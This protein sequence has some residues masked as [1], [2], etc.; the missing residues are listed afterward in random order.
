M[1][2]IDT[3]EGYARGRESSGKPF[4]ITPHATDELPRYARAISFA[5]AGSITVVDI[6][7]E[8]VTIPSGS[9]APGAM[10]PMEIK[11]VR[12]S[13]TTVTGIVGYS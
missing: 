1:P 2:A 6:D 4:L 10:W 7:G 12:V 5:T 9:L 11:A 8:T 3:K 13:G